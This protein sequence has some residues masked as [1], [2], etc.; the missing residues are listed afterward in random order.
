MRPQLTAAVTSLVLVLA[1]GARAQEALPPSPYSLPWQLRPVTGATALRSDS[2]FASYQNAAAQGGFTVVSTLAA[3]YRIPGTGDA[4]GTG[5]AP[6]LKLAAVNDSSPSGPGG[7]AVV[8]PLVG[9]TYARV[10]GSG[11]RASGFLALTI[12]VGMGGGDTPD[13]TL[14]AARSAGQYAR[15]AMD[16]ALFAVND[17][18]LIPGVDVAYVAHGVTV[19][20]EA[21]LFELL[22]VR[23]A[24]AQAE[25]TKTNFT[26]GLHVGYFVV[27]A[28]S[29]GA[30][31]RYQ[32]WL[33]A[34]IAV[35]HDPTGTLV[36]NLTF[37]VGPRL[38]FALAPGT[39]IHPGISF[40]RGLDK[41][42]AGAAN[43]D[44]V[45]LDV[46]VLF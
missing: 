21:T 39:S 2:S 30:D 3:S 23:G 24:A 45:Q 33:N 28:L 11:F 1:G 14:V 40:S 15:S 8:N 7:F 5:L 38:H 43:Y 44:V 29:L 25:T 37:G 32:R 26:T 4:P 41:P 36:D 34:P 9:A 13:K 35:D 19:Q 12:P 22:R 18:A 10:L 17:L 16:N 20:I 46:P 6:V 31:L 42:M 27:D